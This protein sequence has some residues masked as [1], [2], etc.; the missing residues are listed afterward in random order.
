VTPELFAASA[1]PPTLIGDI[2]VPTFLRR[3]TRWTGPV[4][5][6]F[7]SVPKKP[8]LLFEGEPV[9]AEFIV[10]RLLA[11]SGWQGV[12]VKNWKGQAFWRNVMDPVEL[13]ADQAALF[14]RIAQ[15]SRAMRRAETGK[16]PK[17]R[18]G[19]GC[20]DIYAWRGTEVLFVES[21]QHKQDHVRETQRI[22]LNCARSKGVSNFAIVEW[23]ADQVPPGGSRKI[24]GAVANEAKARHDS[25]RQTT[26]SE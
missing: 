17:D 12:W 14:A 16:A 24:G 18:W 26:V 3:E 10:L 19:G 5:K 7:A 22:W 6:S 15:K 21:K 4:P 20:W 1:R 23:R 25:L 11:Y 8:P 2:A 13:A 9:W